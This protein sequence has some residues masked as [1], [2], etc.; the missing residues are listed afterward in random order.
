VFTRGA[1]LV[2][3]TRATLAEAAPGRVVLGLGVGSKTPLRQQGYEVDH[4]VG[5]LQEVVEAVR[6]AWQAPRALDLDGRHVTFRSL[7]LEVRPSPAPPVYLCVGGPRALRL[8]GAIAD[9][10]VL[11][12]FLAPEF[13]IHAR[14]LL[15]AGAGGKSFQG[16]LAGAVII[17][18]DESR[19]AAAAP[20]RRMLAGYLVNFP[21]LA[22]VSGVDPELVERIRDRWNEGGEAAAEIVPDE[23]V[24][25][26]A[27]CGSARECRSRLADYRDAGYELPILFP[28]ASFESCIRDI[29]GA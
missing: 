15:D 10:V 8:A 26:H 11:D 20:L 12:A 6:A 17:S 3:V 14:A 16:E 18:L 25:R 27:L 1:A 24:A 22:E 9:G 4:A 28:V 5:R 19:A 2:A 29:A 23:L 21:E 7:G 13:A